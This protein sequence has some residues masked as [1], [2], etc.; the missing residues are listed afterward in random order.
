MTPDEMQ[1]HIEKRTG[2]ADA[3]M[4]EEGIEVPHTIYLECLVSAR[5]QLRVQMLADED[6]EFS[7]LSGGRWIHSIIMNK[8]SAQDLLITMGLWGFRVPTE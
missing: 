6:V 4:P 5:D 8:E 2:V 1:A 7:F 3:V